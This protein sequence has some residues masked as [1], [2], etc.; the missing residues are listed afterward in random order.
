M[1]RPLKF[2]DAG[3]LQNW[4]YGYFQS[5]KVNRD[6]YPPTESEI[7][8]SE[9]DKT[10]IRSKAATCTDDKHPTISG[11][12]ACLHTNR[13]TLVNYETTDEFFDTVLD[14]KALIEA[15]SEQKLFEASSHGVQFSLTNNYNWKV[16]K[17]IENTQ[18]TGA[19]G[20]LSEFLELLR[21][22]KSPGPSTGT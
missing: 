21:E 19:S 11:L 9:E 2:K 5:C 7:K 4:I 17:E 1:G 20:G 10:P 15:Y 16:K 13:Q 3:E 12:A 18:P 8:K 6:W 14:A 22:I